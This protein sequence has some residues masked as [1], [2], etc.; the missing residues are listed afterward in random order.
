MHRVAIT[1][2][3]V[4]NDDVYIYRFDVN[5]LKKKEHKNLSEVE[6]DGNLSEEEKTVLRGIHK[7][8]LNCA[9]GPS[10]SD[11]GF[12]QKIYGVDIHSLL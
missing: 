10:K 7:R 9:D 4:N 5:W 11:L 1:C 8:H 6:A 12:L 2:M 3:H